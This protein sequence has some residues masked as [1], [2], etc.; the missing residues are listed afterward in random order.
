MC[1]FFSPP[2][3]C[4]LFL[5]TLLHWNFE[6]RV[7]AEWSELNRIVAAWDRR[8]THKGPFP[9]GFSLRKT[10][11]E[12]AI[13][14]WIRSGLSPL[15]PAGGP[16]KGDGQQKG[17]PVHGYVPCSSERSSDAAR[18]YNIALPDRMPYLSTSEGSPCLLDLGC[19][20]RNRMRVLTCRVIMNV[21]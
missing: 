6:P 7:R 21:S 20:Y 4:R 13:F 15:D 16:E 5:T 17:Q 19:F 8:T 10:K 12:N 11:A 2:R 3:A 9:N 1:V 18:C 14:T